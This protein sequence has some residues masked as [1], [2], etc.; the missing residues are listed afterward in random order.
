ML[1]GF[2]KDLFVLPGNE[3]HF[4]DQILMVLKKDFENLNF[5]KPKYIILILV[6][7]PDM[8]SD[9]PKWYTWE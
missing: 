4:Q 5:Y 1:T 3:A 2:T 7:D 6:F 9:S 8:F